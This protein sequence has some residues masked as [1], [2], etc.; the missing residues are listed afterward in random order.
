MCFFLSP[1]PPRSTRT[2]TPFPYTPLFRSQLRFP[3]GR[4]PL[5]H[6]LLKARRDPGFPF[7]HRSND[8]AIKEMLEQPDEYQEVDDLCDQREPVQAHLLSSRQGY[9]VVPERVGEDQDYGHDE[10]VDRSEEH[11]SDIQSLMR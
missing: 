6:G 5:P 2:D 4:R 1:L 9:H 10:T 11:T 7:V 3:L 8:P